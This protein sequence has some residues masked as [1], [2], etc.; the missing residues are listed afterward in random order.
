[1]EGPGFEHSVF[2]VCGHSPLV[3]FFLKS[4]HLR[5]KKEHST[6]VKR[7]EISEQ[8]PAQALCYKD[9]LDQS[10][11]FEK[12]NQAAFRRLEIGNIKIK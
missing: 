2:D 5:H 12:K 3:K 7:T 10:K 1:L 8:P 11:D 4:K 9:I 6:L